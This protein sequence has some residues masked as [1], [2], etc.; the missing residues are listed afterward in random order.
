[1]ALAYSNA[2]K[3]P[4]VFNTEAWNNLAPSI[5]EKFKNLAGTIDDEV[6]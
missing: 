2:T 6:L 5:E 3:F 1:M 4:K